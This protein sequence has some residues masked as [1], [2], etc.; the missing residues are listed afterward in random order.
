MLLFLRMRLVFFLLMSAVMLNI[1]CVR[2]QCQLE[3]QNPALY[4]AIQ[5]VIVKD[6]GNI[7]NFQSFFYKSRASSRVKFSIENCDFTVKKINY[8]VNYENSS[9]FGNCSW[10]CFPDGD[11]YCYLG[12][13]WSL[14]NYTTSTNQLF[15]FIT[16]FKDFISIVDITSF[17]LFD[18]VTF[19]FL[20][21]SSEP[22]QEIDLS[23]H[24]DELNLMPSMDETIGTLKEVL[25]WVCS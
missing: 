19:S 18:K 21:S 25:T 23:I 8:T 3:N 16:T 14:F 17:I 7:L 10:L 15:S 1:M 12:P 9:A 2:V 5:S 11:Y 24:I 6:K 22:D 13:E 4:E 20:S